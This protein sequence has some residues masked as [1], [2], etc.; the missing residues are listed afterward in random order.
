MHLENNGR[1]CAMASHLQAETSAAALQQVY[2]RVGESR[3]RHLNHT[4]NI[5]NILNLARTQRTNPR[6]YWDSSHQ[7]IAQVSLGKGY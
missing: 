2:T 4:S 1:I 3:L 6:L 7:P 5:S